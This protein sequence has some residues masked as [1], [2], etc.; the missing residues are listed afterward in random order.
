MPGMLYS[1]LR[2]KVES[3]RSASAGK[4]KEGT[5][6]Q[7]GL[8]GVSGGLVGGTKAGGHSCGG[9]LTAGPCLTSLA[10]LCRGGDHNF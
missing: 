3:Q 9:P 5:G 10:H 4:G 2:V 6:M 7:A 8:D 1:S